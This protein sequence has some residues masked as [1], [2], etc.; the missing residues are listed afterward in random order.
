LRNTDLDYKLA[1]SIQDGAERRVMLGLDWEATAASTG[2]FK[3][4][5]LKQL[6]WQA[7]NLNSRLTVKNKSY[8]LATVFISNRMPNM[9]ALVWKPV[10]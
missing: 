10:Y 6:M 8:R 9:D 3:V 5:M 2:V 7:V 4:G 1:S